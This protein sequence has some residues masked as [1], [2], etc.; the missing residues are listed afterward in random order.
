MASQHGCFSLTAADF[1]NVQ[2][3]S[4]CHVIRTI[5]I[6]GFGILA[7][8][9]AKRITDSFGEKK[10]LSC[11]WLENRIVALN[12]DQRHLFPCNLWQVPNLS[13]L[14]V[15]NVKQTGKI[16]LDLHKHITRFRCFVSFG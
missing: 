4:K 2:L 9:S 3:I 7:L 5:Q 15:L 1:R 10:N 11:L 8:K 13:E 12:E 6:C 14:H 16:A